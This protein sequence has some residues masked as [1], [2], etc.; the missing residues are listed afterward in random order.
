MLDLCCCTGFSLVVIRGLLMW[1][2]PGPGIKTMFP[3]LAGGFFTAEP[4]GKPLNCTVL[5][6]L[7]SGKLRKIVSVTGLVCG[8][9][10]SDLP[11]DNVMV[12]MWA[13][14]DSNCGGQWPGL[15]D[16]MVLLSMEILF[17]LSDL[18]TSILILVKLLGFFTIHILLNISVVLVLIFSK[19]QPD[20]SHVYSSSFSDCL[21]L[22]SKADVSKSHVN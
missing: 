9:G 2:P 10:S 17:L 3:A 20:L 1:D 8:W 16:L 5:S 18:D 11:E 21:K 19:W 15:W 22:F 6:Q 13:P 4:P 7:S 14:E 12:T